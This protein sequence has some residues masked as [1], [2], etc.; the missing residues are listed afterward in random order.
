[1]ASLLKPWITRYLDPGGR[2]VPK[3]AHGARKVKGRASKWYGQYTDLDGRRRRV[4]LCTDK[5]AAR[6]MLAR[7]ERDV[8]LGRA[9]V[10]DPFAEHRR[11]P[12]ETHVAA[13]EAHLKAKGVCARYQKEHA[14]RLRLVLEHA[15]VRTLADLRPEP[16]EHYLNLLA[17]RGTGA[18][19]RNYYLHSARAFTRWCVRTLRLGEDPLACLQRVKGEV[20]RRRR[21]L[22]E[23]ELVRLLK[24]ARERPLVDV[25]TVRS[26]RTKGQRF[27]APRRPETKA[28]A[29]R[30]GWERAL[31]YK[32]LVLTGLRRGELE[33]LEVR[34]LKLDGLRPCLTLPPA[35]TKNR[36]GADIPL[37]P[38]LV[39]DLRE[40]IA[41]TGKGGE[42]RVFKVIKNLFRVLRDDLKA[43]GIPYKDDQGRTIDVHSLRHTTASHL[44]KGKVAPRVAQGFMRHADIKL[45]MQTYTDPRLL[46]EAE[47]L[48]A[49]P[50]LPLGGRGTAVET[51]DG[52]ETRA[53]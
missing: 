6:Q 49:L 50:N 13:W 3:G 46:D 40:W 31:I 14:R 12:V 39:G 16:V 42:D 22:T 4:P 21:A 36:K 25:T 11:A 51:T 18:T 28:W 20:R 15:K 9:G 34:H 32:T 33:A 7:I 8:Q 41:A 10:S 43:A 47:A 17:E 1:M 27:A 52:G 5:A 35:V 29:E 38:D 53:G 24:A 23:G 2:Q 30:L 26:G 44:G 19:M 48:D 45:T 37:R